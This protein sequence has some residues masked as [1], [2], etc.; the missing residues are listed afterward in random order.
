MPSNTLS[1]WYSTGVFYELFVRSFKDSDGDGNGD[2]KGVLQNIDY[3]EKL[4]ISAIWFM[5]INDSD[6]K[7]DNYDPIN[8]MDVDPT[9]GTLDD[10][11]TLLNELHKRNIK[12]IIDLVVN[13][14]SNKHPFFVDALKNVNSKY[15]D[16]YLWS[17][18]DQGEKGKKPFWHK[19]DTGFY[20]GKFVNTKPDLNYDNPEVLEYMKNVMRFWLDIGVD[21]FR[22]DA[23]A[24]IFEEEAKNFPVIKELRKVLEDDKYKDRD[25]FTIGES[26]SQPY[27]K[28]LGNG[29]DMF[30]AVFNFQT[31][32]KF[33]D[34][35]KYGTPYSSN[36]LFLIE[37]DIVTRYVK[38]ISKVEGAFY[39]TLLTNHDSFTAEDEKKL[40]RPFTLYDGD[41]EKTKLAGSIYLTMPGIPFVYYGEEY[42]MD[43]YTASKSDR[44]LRSCMQWDDSNNAGFTTK[45]KA[46]NLVNENY[47]DY[48]VKRQDGDPNSILT[49]YRSLINIR[50]NNI[51]LSLGSYQTINTQS[52]NKKTTA[53]FIRELGNN[54]IF[55]L[56]NFS[57]KKEN[58]TLDLT[59]TLL[60]NKEIKF[61]KLMG[62]YQKVDQKKN[63]VTFTQV[64]PFDTIVLSY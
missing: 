5:P 18:T 19:S 64:N 56:L 40:K 1:K 14:T 41:T 32:R 60:E 29:K 28:Y 50:K 38:D 22:F 37:A 23:V 20:F 33:L 35:V 17:D 52:K 13:H 3:L 4:G 59:G 39:G 24:D 25:L 55:V 11:K 44:W 53:A 12:V 30:H 6:E 57:S 27:L 51:A 31:N 63:I 7:K 9:Y 43:T 8:F 42:G 46:W 16:W 26:S 2:F 62:R 47:K 36:D 48:N 45:D 54:K 49:H 61:N 34:Y 21:G 58:I 10:F 15:R